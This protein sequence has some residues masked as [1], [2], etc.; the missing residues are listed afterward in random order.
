V[1]P[2]SDPTANDDKKNSNRSLIAVATNRAPI[3]DSN[4]TAADDVNDK[5]HA[6]AVFVGGV[7]SW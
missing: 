7:S 5:S 4:E 1:S 6:F 2:K 3:R